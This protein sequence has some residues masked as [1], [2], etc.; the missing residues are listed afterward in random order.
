MYLGYLQLNQPVHDSHPSMESYESQCK[1]QTL[2]Q[3]ERKQAV[4]QEI[5]I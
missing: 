3:F 4:H 1:Y 2:F 5:N